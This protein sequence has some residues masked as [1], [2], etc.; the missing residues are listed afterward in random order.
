MTPTLTNDL[1]N[2]ANVATSNHKK[3]HLTLAM[4]FPDLTQP[5]TILS[6]MRHL[7][8][9]HPDAFKWMG[10]VNL[11][12]QALF[13]NHRAPVPIDYLPKWAPFMDELRDRDIPLEVHAD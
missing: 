12:K 4:T 6:G 13:N 2:A 11:V 5:E 1:I 7:D 9:Q 10:E 3:V 8:Q